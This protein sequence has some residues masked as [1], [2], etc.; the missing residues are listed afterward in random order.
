[1][2]PGDD[3]E[4]PAPSPD[5][6]ARSTASV[7]VVVA[8]EE[9][10]RHLLARVTVEREIDDGVWHERHGAAGAAGVKLV[11][12]RCGIGTISAAA[13]TER[14]IHVHRPRAVLN[15]GCAGAHRRDILPGDVVVGER[16][17]HHSAV[18]VLAGGEEHYHSGASE[19]AADPL[20]L[21]LAREAAADF[22]PEPWPPEFGWPMAVP[23]RTPTV[24]TGPVASADV[25]TQHQARLDLLHDRHGSLCEDMEAAAV[26]QVCGLH[27]VPF[28]TIKDI[29]NNEFHAATD[30]T[31]DFAGFATAEVG[32]R[33]AALTLRVVE[34]IAGRQPDPREEENR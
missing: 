21:A 18:H 2:S 11:M 23:Y 27:G 9:E 15:F 3:Q 20:L 26:G 10:L 22:V 16:V 1:M 4:P 33:A 13:A 5:G 19:I 25:W 29:S 30:I 28:L 7:G 34:R 31:G 12:I 8:M 24:H 6:P 17:V 14:L 32:K